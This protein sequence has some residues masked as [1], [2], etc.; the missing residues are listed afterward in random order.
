MIL[1]IDIGNTNT[2]V[3]AFEGK[4]IVF[5]SRLATD[6][7]R[8]EDQYALELNSIFSLYNVS[9]KDFTGAII[10]SVVPPLTPYITN[11][12]KKLIGITPLIVGP[13]IKTGLNIR[14]DNPAQLGAD[15]A[16]GAVAASALYPLPCIVFDL[17]TATKASVVDSDGA[18]IGGVIAPGVRIS[19]EALAARTAQLPQI[20]LEAPQK[21]IGTNTIDCMKSGSV[22]GTAAMI[23]GLCLRIEEQLGC[24]ATVVATGGYLPEIAKHCRREI[25]Q[26]DILVLQGLRIIYERNN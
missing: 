6:R 22:F 21:V 15:L 20:D 24:K 1:T 4:D 23:D 11:A 8:M 9:K 26:N 25:I 10:G 18:M 12:I 7:N 3:G 5:V 13:G 16:A 17:G 19:L 2:T 14:I